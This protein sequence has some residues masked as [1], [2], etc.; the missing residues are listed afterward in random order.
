MVKSKTPLLP[1]YKRSCCFTNTVVVQEKSR[2]KCVFTDGKLANLMANGHG[3]H[4]GK[5][6][7]LELFRRV[8]CA[9]GA[10]NSERSVPRI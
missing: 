9:H 2:P 10:W 8:L 7:N 5:D 1:H 3:T 6:D 4:V